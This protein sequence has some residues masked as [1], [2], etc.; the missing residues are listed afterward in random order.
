MAETLQ[1]TDDN[2]RKSM[3]ILNDAYLV[4]HN[5][6]LD[7]QV[8]EALDSILSAGEKGVQILLDRLF[9]GVSLTSGRVQLK[10]WGDMAW[11]EFLKKREVIRCL[12]RGRANGT[13]SRLQEL[14]DADCT[15][16]QWSE[17]VTPALRSAIDAMGAPTGASAGVYQSGGANDAAK[18]KIAGRVGWA[19]AAIV[20]I[21]L[22]G[23]LPTTGAFQTY[24]FGFVGALAG[25]ALGYALARLVLAVVSSRS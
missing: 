2:I 14:L 10:N 12:Q 24:R 4:R 21:V 25:Y 8:E 3:T 16:G 22:P 9:D 13:R 20:A 15:Y 5:P 1:P 23:L 11:N 19:T 7:K 6:E 17:I 18:K